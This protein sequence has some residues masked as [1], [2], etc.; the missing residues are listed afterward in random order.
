MRTLYWLPRIFAAIGTTLLVVALWRYARERGFAA[1]AQRVTGEVVALDLSRNSDGGGT[2][3]PVIRFVTRAGDS[4]QVRSNAGC[5]PPCWDVGDRVDVLYDPARP[6]QARTATFFGQHIASFV[7][8]I[9]GLVFSAVGY[10]WLFVV[11]RRA[12]LE[13][14]LR[15][16][17]R[18]IEA[19]F[20][21]VER[22]ANLQV[23]GVHPWRIVCQWQDATS[24]EV[25]VFHSGN[26]WY[27]PGEYVKETVPVFVDRNDPR[28]YVVDISFLPKAAHR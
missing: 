21:E 6:A 3:H 11:R 18:R 27:D 9:L 16:F 26:I 20:V 23:N 8:G 28:R 24:Q 1:R 25:H 17:G 19:T 5:N 2:Y 7:F 4:V 10:A 15:R 14:E 12:A 22:R 13:E